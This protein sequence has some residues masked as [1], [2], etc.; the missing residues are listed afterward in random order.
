MKKLVAFSLVA[1]FS[2]ATITF[3]QSDIMITFAQQTSPSDVVQEAAESVVQPVE[4]VAPVEATPVVETAPVVGAPVENF[5]PGVQISSP[6]VGG[7]CCGQVSAPIV[8]QP[9]CGAAPMVSAPISQPCCGTAPVVSGPVVSQPSL[10]HQHLAADHPL[11]LQLQPA[12]LLLRQPSQPVASHVSS[13]SERSVVHAETIAA[14]R[15]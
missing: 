6:V 11:L 4:N 14:T 9:C 12:A 10:R 1:F 2:M 5:A 7:G 3:A 8:S 15:Y 13:V